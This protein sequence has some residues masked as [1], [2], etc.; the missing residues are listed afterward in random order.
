MSRSMGC[1]TRAAT[2]APRASNSW[3]RVWGRR[4][5]GAASSIDTAADTFVINGNINVNY[6][7]AAFSPAGAGE[8][9][10]RSG[11]VVEIRGTL[12]GNV[13]TATQLDFEDL[14]TTASVAGPTRSRKS[15]ASSAASP[16]TRAASWSTGAV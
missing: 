2:C 13:F 7:S 1:A 4:L 6:A 3:A 16:P 15:R 9:S 10:L 11:T 14:K 12:A 8:S 5:R